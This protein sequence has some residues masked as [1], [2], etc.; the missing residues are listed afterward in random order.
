LSLLAIWNILGQINHRGITISGQRGMHNNDPENQSLNESVNGAGDGW[1]EPTRSAPQPV[2]IGNDVFRRP[3]FNGNHPLNI[4]RHSTVFDLVRTLEWLPGESFRESKPVDEQTLLEF[5]EQDYVRALRQADVE[6][7]VPPEVRKRHHIGTLANPLFPDLYLRARTAVGGSILAADLACREHIAF[8]PSGG[9]HHGRPD[10]ASGFCYFNDPVFALLQLMKNGKQRILYV[11]LDAHHGDGVENA[12]YDDERVTTVSIHEENRWPYTGKAG[13]TGGRGVFNLPVPAEF[14]DSELDYLL[15]NAV[16][17]LATSLQPD[18][19]VLCCG[20]DCL[21]GDPLSKMSLT[22]AA[23]WHA[24]DRFTGLDVATVILGGGG[25]NPWTV[26]RYWAGIWGRLNR[27]EF[28]TQLPDD[29]RRILAGLECDLIDD[30]EI[31]ENWLRTLVDEPNTGIVRDD[32][33]HVADTVVSE[34]AF[35]D[36]A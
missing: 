15:D 18:A 20:A 34:E 23:L 6:G 21:A 16:L 13:E 3:A 33:K 10:R 4:M 7:T 25:Y 2:Y 8:H 31:E 19:L 5:H 27:H 28:P 36:V 9:T 12:F 30:D 32:V 29:A 35:N 11:D 26:A 17:P 24:I 14:N 22:N 1:S